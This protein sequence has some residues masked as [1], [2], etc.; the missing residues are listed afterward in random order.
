MLHILHSG[1]TQTNDRVLR[2]MFA[3]RKQVFVDLLKWDVPVVD[4]MYEID[5]FDDAHS[6]YLVLTDREG[7]HLGSARLLR[8]DRPH[9]LSSLY[10]ELCADGVPQGPRIREVTRFCLDRRLKAAQRREVRNTLVAALA[11]YAL[12]NGIE[13]YSAIAGI[14]WFEQ[15]FAFGWRCYPLGLPLQRGRATLAALKIEIDAHTPALL[16]TAGIAP[17]PALAG[18]VRAAA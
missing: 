13:S 4:G 6:A 1:E 12:R 7:G 2:A 17:C 9:I 15:I 16:R 18:D 8:T 5:R 10:P 11:E 3:A 14:G